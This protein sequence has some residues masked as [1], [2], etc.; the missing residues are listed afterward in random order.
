MP[1]DVAVQ[2]LVFLSIYYSMT[3]PAIPFLHLYG[4]GVLVVWFSTALG[5]LMSL[6]IPPATSLLATISLLMVGGW[7]EV[8][9]WGVWGWGPPHPGGTQ[10]RWTAM[11]AWALLCAGVCQALLQAV[12]APAQPPAGG[13]MLLLEPI[14]PY[15]PTSSCPPSCLRSRAACSM[16]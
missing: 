16:A 12:S 3:L 6:L 2:P 14:P 11:A 10:R 8:G 5:H 9:G 13:A 15:T 7:V 4:V 1:A